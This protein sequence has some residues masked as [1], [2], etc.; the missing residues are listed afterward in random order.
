MVIRQRKQCIL[1]AFSIFI[2]GTIFMLYSRDS[3]N[4]DDRRISSAQ[5]TPAELAQANLDNLAP[6]IFIG[7]IPRLN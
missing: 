5:R 6:F 1:L 3:S 7:G 4:L 2:F